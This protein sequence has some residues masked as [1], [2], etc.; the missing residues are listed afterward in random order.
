MNLTWEKNIQETSRISKFSTSR[1]IQQPKTKCYHENC[2]R[3]LKRRVIYLDNRHENRKKITV[4]N[5]FSQSTQ[6]Q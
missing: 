2:V 5:N 3:Y 4:S 6:K 1:V